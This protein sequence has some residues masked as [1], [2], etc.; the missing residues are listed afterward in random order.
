MKKLLFPLAL[1]S[2]AATGCGKKDKDDNQNTSDN[3]WKVNGTTYKVSASQ[4]NVNGNSVAL[5]ATDVTSLASPANS[6]ALVF[7]PTPVGSG[8]IIIGDDTG[9]LGITVV[10]DGTPDKV[11]YNQDPTTATASYSYQNGLLT[12]DIPETW[13]VNT[14]HTDSVR[15]SGH[16][17]GD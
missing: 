10:M 3:Y 5:T 15:F 8:S 17:Y 9:R 16:V 6:V 1:L 14:D 12:V 7:D 2:L 11:Y 4:T 13:V